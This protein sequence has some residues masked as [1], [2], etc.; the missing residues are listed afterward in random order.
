MKKTDRVTI[1]T[2]DKAHFGFGRPTRYTFTDYQKAKAFSNQDYA[3]LPVKR[4]YTKEKARILLD[5]A[6]EYDLLNPDF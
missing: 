1:W 3:D 2:V 6:F 5:N 4:T